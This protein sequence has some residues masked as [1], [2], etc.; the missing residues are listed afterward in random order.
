MNQAHARLARLQRVRDR[1]VELE[2][3]ALLL[4]LGADLP[5]LTGYEA[6][7]L[8][9]LTMLVVP[10]DAPATLVVPRLEAPR[11]VEHPEVF[12]LRPWAEQEDPVELVASLVGGRCRLAVSDRT[13]ATFVLA[14]QSRL[15]GSAWRPSSAVTGPLRAVKDAAE[16]EALAAA[17]AAADRVAQQLLDGDIPLLGR[18][19]R[20]VSQ[21][22]GRRLIAEGHQRVN[23]AIVG[24]GPNAASP[25]H[26]PEGRVI[27]V[28]DAVVCDFGGTMDG[29]CSDITRTVWTGPPAAEAEKL[30]HIL[31]RAQAAG[32]AAAVTG[33]ACES[34]DRTA[35]AMIAEGGYGD[36]FIHRTGHG[37]GLEEHE[38]PYIVAGNTL[39]LVPGHAFSVEPGIYLSG[40]YGARIEDIVVAAESRPP[41]PQSRQPRADRGGGLTPML[42]GPVA[43]A[44]AAALAGGGPGHGEVG[45][46]ATARL[47]AL[48]VT[49]GA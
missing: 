35:R 5:W 38:D 13:W 41:G 44:F 31:Q 18:M 36:A 2:V 8:E 14:L 49:F 32:V 33:A 11:V 40:H 27:E 34:V 29:Y 1:M 48:S 20:D 15:P 45:G 22:I 21:D 3:D 26:E 30:Y 28:G 24:S 23:F 6:M 43:V 39:P 47:L 25:H 16:I 42:S 7:A 19:E 12:A 9:R 46:R 4:S 10:A 37:I 17:S